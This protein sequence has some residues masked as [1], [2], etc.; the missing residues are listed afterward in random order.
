M[1]TG[2][3]V[4]SDNRLYI[5]IYIGLWLFKRSITL[6]DLTPLALRPQPVN[7][8]D[9]GQIKIRP[10]SNAMQYYVKISIQSMQNFSKIKISR[11]IVYVNVIRILRNIFL[12]NI[13]I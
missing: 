3:N 6:N 1:R 7:K 10:Y 9:S 11:N 8:C 13:E 5:K 4:M 2:I 12:L